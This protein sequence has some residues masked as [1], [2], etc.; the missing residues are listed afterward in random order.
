MGQS[1]YRAQD[2]KPRFRVVYLDYYTPL[3]DAE[4][5]MRSELT[6]DGVHLNDEGYARISPVVIKAAGRR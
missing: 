2:L 6:T 1:G 5:R 3:A 4:G